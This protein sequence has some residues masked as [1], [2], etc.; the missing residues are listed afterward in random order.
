MK[1]IFIPIIILS[2]LCLLSK[3]LYADNSAPYLRYKEGD[4]FL[5]SKDS[6]D[7]EEI[8]INTPLYDGDTIWVSDRGKA[9]LFFF[10]SSVVR[11]NT[12]TILQILTP[13]K[14]EYRLYLSTGQAYIHFKK[15]GVTTFSIDTPYA[16]LHIPLQSIFRIDVREPGGTDVFVMKGEIYA[17]RN[18]GQMRIGAGAGFVFRDHALL[19]GAQLHRKDIWEQWNLDRDKELYG[20][21]YYEGATYLPDELNA[22]YP[23]LNKNGQ[24]YNTKEYGY[25]WV[26]TIISSVHWSPYRIGR[27][28]WIRGNYVWISYEPWGWVPYHYGRWAYLR[29]WGWC[30]VPPSRGLVI[31][32]PGY[33]AWYYT[34]THISWVP[35]APRE[36][37]IAY[38]YYGPYSTRVAYRTMNIKNVYRNIY[39]K[40]AVIT[41][42]HNNFTRGH[43]TD[44]VL[45]TNP[46]LTQRMAMAPPKN[47]AIYNVSIKQISLPHKIQDRQGLPKVSQTI[48]LDNTS[49]K[50]ITPVQNK[51]RNIQPE[52]V[53]KR[54][55]Q[56]QHSVQ[57]TQVQRIHHS[58]NKTLLIKQGMQPGAHTVNFRN[59]NKQALQRKE[60]IVPQKN[61]ITEQKPL[62]KNSSRKPPPSTALDRKAIS[63][64][65]TMAPRNNRATP[66]HQKSR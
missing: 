28:K 10:D 56:N 14:N 40:N 34:S 4:I 25:V 33:V 53:Q 59:N 27:W 49:Q 32:A 19:E 48:V 50:G 9:E 31:W 13:K 44:V 3:S 36:I 64:K 23:D 63:D 20:V 17:L 21:Y 26:P 8:T 62:V 65:N 54:E 11:L 43:Y 41:V 61:K 57:S 29:P 30:W 47:I 15:K 60:N 45:H 55:I 7:W 37:Y 24:W 35:L 42:S 51:T 38:D 16:S 52:S 18:N 46:F 6:S 5:K 58:N 66:F 1:K 22:Y 2:L 39:V 12:N